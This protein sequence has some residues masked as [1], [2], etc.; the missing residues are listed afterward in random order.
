MTAVIVLKKANGKINSALCP[1]TNDVAP[2]KSSVVSGAFV[3]FGA[4]VVLRPSVDFGRFVSCGCTSSDTTR[5]VR[6]PSA[7]LTNTRIQIANIYIYVFSL[8]WS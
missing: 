3:V 6:L 4:F 1:T 2:D 7:D 8:T 5:L